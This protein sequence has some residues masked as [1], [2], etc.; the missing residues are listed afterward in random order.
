MLC[1][2]RCDWYIKKGVT[3]PFPPPLALDHPLSPS[4][5][6]SFFAHPV[7]YRSSGTRPSPRA[8]S[9]VSS[10]AR[11][12]RTDSTPTPPR[13]RSSSGNTGSRRPR[14][15]G[16]RSSCRARTRV[17]LAPPP[18]TPREARLTLALC[19]LARASR[20]R[21]GRARFRPRGAPQVLREVNP[22]PRRIGGLD[23]L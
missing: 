21:P 16:P 13:R 11:P 14:R 19:F 3:D 5:R 7:A 15:R 6:H 4:P 18:A 17:R 22:S 8:S 10:T 9:T 20:D 2:I 12:C 23:G 1:R